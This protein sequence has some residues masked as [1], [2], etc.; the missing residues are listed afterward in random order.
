MPYAVRNASGHII[1]LLREEAP[2]VTENLSGAHPEVIAFLDREVGPGPFGGLDAEFVRVMEDLIDVL[3]RTGVVRITDLPMAAQR[4]LRVRKDA[5]QQ[6]RETVDP[7]D[8]NGV[9]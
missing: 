3:V 2:G 4:K 1:A 6:I 7:L 5:R 9:L 8:R